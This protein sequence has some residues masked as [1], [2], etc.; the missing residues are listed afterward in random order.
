MKCVGVGKGEEHVRGRLRRQS[1]F[2]T[3]YH[4]LRHKEYLICEIWLSKPLP[5]F[6][7]VQCIEETQQQTVAGR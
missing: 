7:M 2:C 6:Y 3:I 1:R 4:L 5:L